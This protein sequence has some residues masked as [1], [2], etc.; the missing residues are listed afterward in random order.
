MARI[1][2]GGEFVAMKAIA[3]AG[4]AMHDDC[5]DRDV[6]SGWRRHWTKSNEAPEKDKV[7]RLQLESSY[8]SACN[9]RSVSMSSNAP[10]AYIGVTPTCL[11]PRSVAQVPDCAF[12]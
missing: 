1:F 12:F 10:K 11:S 2:E 8:Q 4:E 7:V 6:E 3:L 9:E 5:S